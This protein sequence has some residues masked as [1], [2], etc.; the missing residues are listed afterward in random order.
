MNK[1]KKLYIEFLK[2]N[3]EAL[4]TTNYEIGNYG[5]LL[6]G[7]TQNLKDFA[8]LHFINRLT[9]N[10]D[11]KKKIVNEFT[12]NNYVK[13]TIPNIANQNYIRKNI[14]TT[15][16][17]REVLS[18]LSLSSLSEDY[19]DHALRYFAGIA[20]PSVYRFL[21]TDLRNTLKKQYD[22]IFTKGFPENI[23]NINTGIMTANAG[24]SAQFMFI[25]RAIL[26]GF[27]CS[28]VDVRSSRY[29]AIID[30]K[31][32]LLRIQV[33]G[34]SGTS[35]SFKDRDRGGQGI[36]H[37]HFRNV[38]KRVS[39]TDCDIYVAVDRR[40]GTCYII[41]IEEYI[42]P[43]PDEQIHKPI[44]ISLLGDYKENWKIIES[45]ANRK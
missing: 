5:L 18:R 32:K 28:N 34:L 25:S 27:N 26:F 35:I 39:S 6:F 19:V 42:D 37:T 40:F 11:F 2:N 36:D 31:G 15:F 29:D 23:T 8:D 13:S 17:D 10:P 22:F 9:F 41:P 30:F 20:P 43:I 21:K 4:N 3:I 38:G 44:N 24:D 14:L 45:I 33:K 12:K 7:S 16:Y 1:K